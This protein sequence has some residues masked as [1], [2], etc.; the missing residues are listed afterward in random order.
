[1]AGSGGFKFGT[2]ATGTSG[3]GAAGAFSF[4]NPSATA[5]PTGLSFGT[6]AP[7]PQAPTGV[8][9]GFKFAGTSSPATNLSGGLQLGAATAASPASKGLGFGLGSTTATP[10]AGTGLTLGTPSTGTGLSLGG[11]IGGTSAGT[12]LSLGVAKPGGLSLAGAKPAGAG[13]S[14]SGTSGTGLTLGGTTGTGFGIGGTAAT[15]SGLTLGVVAP[16]AKVGLG[17][18]DP[19][20]LSTSIATTSTT[21]DSTSKGQGVKETN[22]PQPICQNVKAFKAYVKKQKSTRE[23]ILRFSDKPLHRVREETAA[24]HQLLRQASSSLQRNAAAVRKLKEQSAQQLKDVEIAQRTREIPAA[25]QLEYSAPTEY[26]Q[27]L[28]YQFEQDMVLCRQQI[29]QMESFMAALEQPASYSPQELSNIMVK[30]NETFVALAAQLQGVH[31]IIKAQKEQYLNYRRVY[32]GDSTDVFS[33]RRKL[34]ERQTRSKTQSK[35]PQPFTQF[36]N[37]ALVMAT[38]MQSAQ[39][40]TGMGGAMGGA[41]GGGLQ[42]GLGARTG[43]GGTAGGLGGTATGLGGTGSTF[44]ATSGFGAGFQNKG[45]GTGTGT[46]GTGSTLGT[47]LGQTASTFGGGG[48]TGGLFGTNPAAATTSAPG[49]NFGGSLSAGPNPGTTGTA[50]TGFGGFGTT[51]AGSSFGSTTT[52]KPLQLQKPPLKTRKSTR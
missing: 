47:G 43:L 25:L 34:A 2:T 48:G 18:V 20:T 41:M 8:A 30:L 4:G 21:S 36:P 7:N 44:G 31:E 19:S 35:G 45:F 40:P 28:V 42:T 38:A 29:E 32:L 37:M 23:E 10:A 1:M 39:K 17:G 15:S 5:K 16:T 46:F 6:P 33:A 22:V 14:L 49:F 13:F 12:G 27:R 3:G 11:T 24:L 51:A 9:T 26:F 52:G 50:A